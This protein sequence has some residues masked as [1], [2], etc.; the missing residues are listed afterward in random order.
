MNAAIE[1]YTDGSCNPQLKIGGWAALIIDNENRHLIKG[2][3]K[4]VTHN[5]MELLAVINAVEFVENNKLK[6]K[7]IVVYTDS[8]YVADLVVR[9]NKLKQNNYLTKKGKSIQNVELVKKIVSLLSSQN[10]EFIKVKAHQK[11]SENNNN[12][13]VDKVSRKIVRD[14]IA[15]SQ[16]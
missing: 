12:R 10:I 9:K 13:I 2:I 1:I 8:Q 3:K 5:S 16:A 11:H 7:K 6:Y 14:W 4:Q 15:N